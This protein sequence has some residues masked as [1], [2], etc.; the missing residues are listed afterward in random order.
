MEPVWEMG[1][2]AKSATASRIYDVTYGAVGV[3]S[4]R[5]YKRRE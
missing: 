3:R 1:E 5:V 4:E 2:E